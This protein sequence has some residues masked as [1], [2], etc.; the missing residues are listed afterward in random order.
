MLPFAGTVD[1]AYIPNGVVLGLSKL[2]RLVDLFSKRLQIQER[3]TANI[4]IALQENLNPLGVAV[5][6][7]ATHSC[8]TTRGAMKGRSVMDTTYFTGAYNEQPQK[9]QEFWEMLK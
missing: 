3:M 2:A 4:A 9:R 7:S 8:M 1:I 6:V 5:R